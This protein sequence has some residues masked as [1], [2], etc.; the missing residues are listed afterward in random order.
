LTT[1][2][3]YQVKQKGMFK[4]EIDSLFHA[5]IH[6]INYNIDGFQGWLLHFGTISILTEVGNF[7][8]HYVPH[9]A[10]LHQQMVEAVRDH[11]GEDD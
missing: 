10:E 5:R 1:E 6:G 2:R 3:I 8:I 4:H 9:P 11:I 7:V